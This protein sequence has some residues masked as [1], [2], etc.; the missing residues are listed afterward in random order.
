M[1][2]LMM[3]GLVTQLI[4]QWKV[5]VFSEEQ[6]GMFSDVFMAGLS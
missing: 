6:L 2:N 4:G 3:F 1:K 5:R